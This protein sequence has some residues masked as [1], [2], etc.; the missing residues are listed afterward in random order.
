MANKDPYEQFLAEVLSAVPEENRAAI[1]G[2][3]KNEQLAPRIRER[4]LARSDY[5]RQSDTLRQ[6][7]LA[8]EAQVAEAKNKISGWE[9]WYA[10][11]SAE[12]TRLQAE[13][14]AYKAQFGDVDGEPVKQPT[15]ITEEAFNNRLTSELDRRDRD[16]IAFA[17]VLTE[18]KLDHRDR[19]KEKLNTAELVE[20]ATK[21]GLPLQAAYREYVSPK[22]E[23]L[24]EADLSAKLKAAKEEG[25]REALSQHRL[26]TASG[27]SEVHTLDRVADVGKTSSDRVRNAVDNWNKS[28]HSL[29]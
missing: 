10:Q 29:Y 27:F 19:F 18:L 12:Q 20:F 16:A 22:E 11:T 28:N 3:L 8:F 13:N 15:G 21:N 25:A 14:A 23:E 2:T 6:E 5:S 24:R 26:P 9:N 1:E 17:D 7:R 4:V